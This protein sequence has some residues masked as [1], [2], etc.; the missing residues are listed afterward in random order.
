MS[1]QRTNNVTI[2][3]RVIPLFFIFLTD[4]VIILRINSHNLFINQSNRIIYFI[5]NLLLDNELYFS[6]TL[7]GY[8]F[9]SKKPS[10]L[11]SSSKSDQCTPVL[12]IVC[13]NNWL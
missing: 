8:S 1:S 12:E 7:S 3:E 13:F 9:V 4:N 5:N 10:K 2:K 11:K 6:A